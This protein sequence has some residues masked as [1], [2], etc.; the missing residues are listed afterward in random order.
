VAEGPPVTVSYEL[1]KAGTELVPTI[2]QLGAW[3]Q[4]NLHPQD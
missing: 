2:E 4:R 1:T 3:A